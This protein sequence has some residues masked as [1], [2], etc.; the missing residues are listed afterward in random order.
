MEGIGHNQRR[1]SPAVKKLRDFYERIPGAAI[2]RKEFGYYVMDKWIAQGY[3]KPYDAVPDHGAYIRELFGMDENVFHYVTGIGDCTAEMFPPFE[4]KVLEDRGAHE[5]VQDTAGRSVLYFKGRRNGFMPEYVDHP[6]RDMD[7]W[8]RNVK[9]R[10]DP[11]T[12]GRDETIRAELEN[13][14]QWQKQG[15]VISQL[16]GGGYMY[17]RSLIGGEALLYMVYDD[18]ALIHDCMKTWFELA[19]ARIAYH[20]R[21]VD[22]DELLLDEDVCYNMGP[23]ISPEM[24]REFLFPYYQQLIINMKARSRDPQ[25]KLH[26]QLAT[27]GC[28]PA[29]IDLYR[30]IGCDYFSPFEVA[31]GCDVVATG[32]KYPDILMSGGI[33]K[34]IIAEG[35][36]AIKRH[37]EHIMPAMRARGGYIPTCDHGVPEE[38]SFE[39][40]MRYRELLN[41]YCG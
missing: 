23:L 40:Y 8:Q 29:V 26:V 31:S 13:A 14:V 9:W 15:H 3:V 1:W 11:A 41:S 4:E 24:I 34:R 5:L 32:R 21:F 22:F 2:Y 37:L 33:D 17:L 36:D 18:P 19:D 25:R 38:V 16:S 30:E 39:N 7:S 10:L 27:D 20:Q 12:P 35:G 28:L 6:V